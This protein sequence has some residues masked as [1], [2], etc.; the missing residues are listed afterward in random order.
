MFVL[1][2]HNQFT[3]TTTILKEKIS[4]KIKDIYDKSF[5]EAVYTIVSNK[6]GEIDFELTDD[7][8]QELDRRKKNHKNGSS[9]SYSWQSVKKAAL[10]AKA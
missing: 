8:K 2:L 1:L 3:M 10:Q 9:K 4:K 6:A 5:L 7:L